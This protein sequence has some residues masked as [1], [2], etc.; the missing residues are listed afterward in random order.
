LTIIVFE[1]KL[2]IRKTIQ[3]R[4]IYIYR[5]KILEQENTKTSNLVHNITNINFI[6]ILRE[7]AQKRLDIY[8]VN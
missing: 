5:E 2:D 8:C 7:N 4:R 6:D 3:K 1:K